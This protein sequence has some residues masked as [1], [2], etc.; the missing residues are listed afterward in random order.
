MK[1]SR[2]QKEAIIAYVKSIT[3]VGD[4]SPDNFVGA[5]S[6]YEP[7]RVIHETGSLDHWSALRDFITSNEF[8]GRVTNHN[9]HVGFLWGTPVRSSL[10]HGKVEYLKKMAITLIETWEET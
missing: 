10:T 3:Y 4:N 9:N 2:I 5:I 8:N 1:I 7:W 6:G